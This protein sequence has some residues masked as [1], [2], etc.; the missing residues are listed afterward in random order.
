MGNVTPYLSSVNFVSSM[1][2]PRCWLKH[3]ADD[4][5]PFEIF[6]VFTDIRIWYLMQ[7]VSLEYSVANYKQ[8]AHEPQLSPEL[9]ALS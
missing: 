2:M 3:S 1:S 4:K 8:E 7:T 5:L 6:F 9:T